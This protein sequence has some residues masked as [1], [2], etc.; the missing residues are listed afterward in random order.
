MKKK[1]EKKDKK[2]LKENSKDKK[3]IKETK[4]KI[5]IEKKEKPK[6]DDLE[7]I[8]IEEDFSSDSGLQE[9]GFRAPVLTQMAEAPKEGGLNLEAGMKSAPKTKDKEPFSYRVDSENEEERKYAQSSETYNAPGQVDF[10][11]AGRT[12]Q[13]S[14]PDEVAFMPSEGTMENNSSSGETY[15]VERTDFESAGKKRK[16]GFEEIGKFERKYEV[17]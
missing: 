9:I 15:S 17:K 4:K 12:R 6:D 8:L 3:E 13:S 5:L 10:S 7:E 16:S 2:E 11:Q 14:S 1:E